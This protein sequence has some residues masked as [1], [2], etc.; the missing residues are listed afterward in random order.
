MSKPNAK[1]YPTPIQR[2]NNRVTDDI[3]N[4]RHYHLPLA[5]C[6]RYYW[7]VA[8]IIKNLIEWC[9]EKEKSKKFIRPE[10]YTKQKDTLIP[11]YRIIEREA[12]LVESIKMK[13]IY[14]TYLGELVN[15]SNEKEAKTKDTKPSAEEQAKYATGEVNMNDF[16]QKLYARKDAEEMKQLMRDMDS[17]IMRFGKNEDYITDTIQTF[18]A[19]V[20][21]LNETDATTAINQGAK[22]ADME[23]KKLKE[24]GTDFVERKSD[25]TSETSKMNSDQAD[26]SFALIRD[27]MMTSYR[28]I[29]ARH[30]MVVKKKNYPLR[31]FV[32]TT[33]ELYGSI[34]EDR[35]ILKKSAMKQ[36]HLLQLAYNQLVA[37]TTGKSVSSA[38]MT[39]SPQMMRLL[40]NMAMELHILEKEYSDRWL[41]EKQRGEPDSF[42]NIDVDAIEAMKQKSAEMKTTDTLNNKPECEADK[43]EV[44]PDNNLS[45]PSANDEATP[46]KQSETTNQL[47]NN[48]EQIVLEKELE[49]IQITD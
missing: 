25:K 46:N 8:I 41:E 23:I 4:P 42:P 20:E 36:T 3:I 34:S 14:R 30:I 7:S 6:T 40:Q 11:T 31:H 39:M 44:K 19:L 28:S 18:L 35:A 32:K 5:E 12:V 22:M 16:I 13:P 27:S 43:T 15:Y 2:F 10:G 33:E 24:N 45:H 38:V 47:D 49:K 17:A 21:P 9:V 1:L 29:Y 26:Q 48:T 37:A